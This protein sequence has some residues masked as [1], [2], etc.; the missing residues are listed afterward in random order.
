MK[1]IIFLMRVCVAF[2]LF[3]N[4]TDKNSKILIE[5]PD[6]NFK[7]Y[8][9]ENFDKNK[10]GNISLAEASWVK[11]IDC[12]NRNIQNLSGIE[13]F[14]ELESLNCSNNQLDELELQ[15]NKKLNRLICTGNNDPFNIYVGFSSP[16]LISNFKKPAN[17][18]EPQ[19]NQATNPL[20]MTKCSFDNNKMVIIAVKY[21][22]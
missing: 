2:V 21:D 20:D 4:C 12:S 6:A 22:Y 5:I 7:A 13:K 10:D 3:T 14:M 1:K 19:I 11:E 18:V 8:L 9:L 15:Y 17:N 16:L